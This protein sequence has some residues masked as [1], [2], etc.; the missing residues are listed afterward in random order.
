M[1]GVVEEVPAPRARVGLVQ[2]K[3]PAELV[4]YQHSQ[5]HQ[6]IMQVEVEVVAL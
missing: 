4:Y 6:L 3:P 1:A 5:E 2:D